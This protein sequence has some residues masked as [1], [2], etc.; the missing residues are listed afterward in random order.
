M[1]T[2]GVQVCTH[3]IPADLMTKPLPR[4]KLEQLKKLMGCRFVGQYLER[5]GLHYAEIVV[6]LQ[7][8]TASK[9][10]RTI[11]R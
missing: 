4:P 6:S 3:V 1:D 5:A 2:R 9:V 7:L 8:V 11:V 10:T